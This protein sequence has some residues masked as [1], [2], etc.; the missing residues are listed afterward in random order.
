MKRTVDIGKLTGKVL[1]FGGVYSNYQALLALRDICLKQNIPPSQVL[2]TGDIVAYCAQPEECVQLIKDWGI[3]CIIGNVEQQIREG[4]AD[5]ACDFTLGSTCDNLSKEWYPYAYQ[6]VSSSS[7]DWMK[8]LPDHLVF[9]Y[10]D[11]KGL[12]VHGSY[13]YISEF[14]FK[15]TDWKIKEKQFTDNEVDLI[16]AGHCGLPFSQEVKG[17]HWLNAGVIGMPANDATTDVWYMILDDQDGLSY[18][19][20]RLTYDYAEAARLMHQH[21]LPSEY[22][23]TLCTGLWDNCEILP[24]VETARQG[25]K[26]CTNKKSWIG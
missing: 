13:G 12:V 22:A 19:H 8:T 16:L 21:N 26:I 20:Y 4:Q 10:A 24:E 9:E 23:E 6:A 3:H 1:V 5:C 17:K 25:M 7:V 15:S 18:T 14:I 11:K 2:C